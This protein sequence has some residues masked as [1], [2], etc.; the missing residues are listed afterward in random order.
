M[1]CILVANYREIAD[2]YSDAQLQIQGVTDY[3]YNAA[4]E[5]VMLQ[6]FDPELDLL[7]PFYNAYLASQ[8]VYEQ[9]PQ[10]VVSA[11]TQLQTHIIDKARTDP[12]VDTDTSAPRR[13]TDINQWI[14]AHGDNVAASY[15]NVGRQGDSGA[16]FTVPT[17]FAT[18]SDQAGFN[19]VTGNITV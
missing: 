15:D 9:A 17:D 12:T 8:T 5:I 10:A 11:V 19:I 18:L 2:Y 6:V 4:Y 14:D 16:S 3:Y 13:F 7:A 1:A